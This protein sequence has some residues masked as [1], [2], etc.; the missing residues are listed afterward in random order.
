MHEDLEQL[1]IIYNLLIS[2]RKVVLGS[3]QMHAGDLNFDSDPKNRRLFLPP[4]SSHL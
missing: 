2:T 1:L 3:V 4:F